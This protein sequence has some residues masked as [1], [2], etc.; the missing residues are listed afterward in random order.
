M[1]HSQVEISYTQFRNS[2]HRLL[3]AITMH[4]FSSP[5]SSIPSSPR[6]S[7]PPPLLHSII[8]C[9]LYD[10]FFSAFSAVAFKS[11]SNSLPSAFA[12]VPASKLLLYA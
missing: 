3:K 8:L 12:S 6:S 5:H 1:P 7:I 4:S 2:M 10:N 9:I 11:A